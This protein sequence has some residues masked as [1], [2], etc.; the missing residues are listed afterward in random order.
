MEAMS[1]RNVTAG[2][3]APGLLSIQMQRAASDIGN[4]SMA[5]VN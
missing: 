1:T 4:R 3:E 2:Q 5:A